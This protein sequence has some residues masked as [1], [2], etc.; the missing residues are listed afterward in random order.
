[1]ESQKIII[2]N[3][4][5]DEFSH[6]DNYI[7]H[8][9]HE[10]AY[11]TNLE[12]S[13]ANFTNNKGIFRVSDLSDSIEVEKAA[14]NCHHI[15][16]SVTKIIALS[17]F[18]QDIAA[19]LRTKINVPGVQE[20]QVGL[21]RDKVLMKNA[22][23]SAGLLCPE[24]GSVNS[25][26]D[27]LAFAKVTSFPIILKPRKGASSKGVIKLNSIEDVQTSKNIDLSNYECER[28]IKGDIYHIDGAVKN[29]NLLFAQVSR[30]INTCLDFNNQLPLGSI[31]VDDITLVNEIKQF[32]ILVL[33]ALKISTGI[34]HL[35]IIRDLD[36]NLYFLEIGAR[37]GGGEIPYV[38]K[39]VHDIDL[40]GI[41]L[42]LELEE[43]CEV[44]FKNCVTG[45][46]MFPEPKEFPCQVQEI[47]SLIGTIKCLYSEIIP[48]AGHVFNGN[49]GYS[50]ISGK[51]R[52]KA[53]NTAEIE[54]A[55]YQTISKFK[56]NCL[57]L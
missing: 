16:N 14:L 6:Y 11:I 28:F 37:S 55:I 31:V 13:P 3:R 9:Y 18:D 44:K 35:E 8:N 56:I 48:T 39:D 12:I 38:L 32:S 20:N 54:E 33:N 52:Y 25:T 17:E 43:T 7:D 19:F 23:K 2:I 45:F 40:M 30:Y 1:M 4:W 53:S 22:I 10:V 26:E 29:S 5:D 41:A 46:L 51:F 36:N 57:S 24:Y 50:D 42:K 49:G 47:T 27:I 15:M 21:Y 34:F